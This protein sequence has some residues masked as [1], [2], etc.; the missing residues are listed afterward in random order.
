MDYFK[1]KIR[2]T[3]NYVLYNSSS[4]IQTS[5]I[6]WKDSEPDYKLKIGDGH[7]NIPI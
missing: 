6:A 1:D 7:T 4:N 5:L 2:N 3:A